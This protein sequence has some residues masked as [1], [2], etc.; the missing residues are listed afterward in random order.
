[1]KNKL[2][3]IVNFLFVG[4]ITSSSACDDEIKEIEKHIV[5]ETITPEKPNLFVP[6][7]VA[8]QLMFSTIR[9]NTNISYGTGFIFNFQPE[10]MGEDIYYPCLVTNRH[11]LIN[12]G[13]EAKFGELIFHKKAIDKDQPNG[14]FLKLSFNNN[15]SKEWIFHPDKDLCILPLAHYFPDS[16]SQPFF[17]GVAKRHILPDEELYS[18]SAAEEVIMVG[19]PREIRD[20]KYNFPLFRRGI[21]ASHPAFDFC[22]DPGFLIDIASFHGSSGSPVF[23]HNKGF[24]RVYN[25]VFY[26]GASKAIML[27]DR[28]IF[29]GLLCAGPFISVDGT[30]TGTIEPSLL[31]SSTNITMHLG[32]VINAK[33]LLEFE[34]V[35]SARLKS[36]AEAIQD[37]ILHP[38]LDQTR[39]DID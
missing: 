34:K 24:Y 26:V 25:K 39:M 27:K 21:C 18:L 17:R 7:T 12:E 10:I 35:L 2:I 5:Y 19:Y 8:D 6:K 31:K 29:M 15:F 33:I 32:C 30:V 1:M 38:I 28:L 4:I 16:E 14:E 11:V 23:I 22:G 9:I 36:E 20:N 3:L 37:K 13:K